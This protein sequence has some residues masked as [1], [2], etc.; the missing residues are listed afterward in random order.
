MKIT[1]NIIDKIVRKI[2]YK[3]MNHQWKN[4]NASYPYHN[5][6]VWKE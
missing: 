4:A 2:L 1:L 6:E 5:D 3:G